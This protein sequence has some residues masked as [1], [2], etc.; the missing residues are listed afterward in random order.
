[1]NEYLEVTVPRGTGKNIQVNMITEQ[2]LLAPIKRGQKL[3]ILSLSIDGAPI[4]DYPLLALEN[5]GV[6]G[7]LGRGWD[8]ILLMFK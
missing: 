1:M 8:S 4:G 6:T 2:P 7:I 3:G 5:V